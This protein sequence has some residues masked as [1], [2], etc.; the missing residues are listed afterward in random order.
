[1]AIVPGV[2]PGTWI[3]V[4]PGSSLGIASQ[5][6]PTCQLVVVG[7]H[8]T[9]GKYPSKP[10]ANRV[11]SLN[12]PSWRRY[13]RT[14]RVAG[15]VE[16]EVGQHHIVDVAQF[17]SLLVKA[18]VEVFVLTN[19]VVGEES[20]IPWA[21]SGSPSARAAGVPQQ[22]TL[23]RLH[24]HAVGR[25]PY[26]SGGWC[27]CVRDR[28]VRPGSSRSHVRSQ[29]MAPQSRILTCSGRSHLVLPFLSLVVSAHRPTSAA[30]LFL[31]R[32][33]PHLIER[34]GVIEGRCLND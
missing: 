30:S 24:Q 5:R 17:Q 28:M 14:V 31:W 22:A 10:K 25:G 21:P 20:P 19:L 15:V 16:V 34:D 2:W 6:F 29:L 32:D 23:W 26:H 12:R 8:V 27:F 18:G 33:G 1:M 13:R 3:R 9:T 7:L 4:T 11:R